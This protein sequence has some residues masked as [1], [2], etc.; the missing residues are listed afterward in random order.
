MPVFG[1]LLSAIFLDEIPQAFH[2][3]GIALIFTGI[4]LTTSRKSA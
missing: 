4:F 1:I 2:F 3:V